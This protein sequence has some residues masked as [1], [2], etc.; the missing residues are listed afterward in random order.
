[1]KTNKPTSIRL[2]VNIAQIIKELAEKENRSISAQIIQILQ[3]Y[4]RNK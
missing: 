1:M 4:L 2:P 3:E